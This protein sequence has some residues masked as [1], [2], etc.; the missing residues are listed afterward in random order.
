MV[1][2]GISGYLGDDMSL[3]PSSIPASVLFPPLLPMKRAI[4]IY[5][6]LSKN[7]SKSLCLGPQIL[8]HMKL[9]SAN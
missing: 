2:V 1:C 7:P 3:F 4:N 6:E 5:S 8:F 9:S